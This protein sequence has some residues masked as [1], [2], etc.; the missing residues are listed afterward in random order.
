M[1]SLNN[2][3]ELV[4]VVIPCFNHGAFLKEAVDSA[5]RSKYSPIEI[6]IVDDGSSDNSGEVAG[7]IMKAHKN[8]SYY[9]QSNQGPSVARNKGIIE[10]K[11][12]YILPLDA[13]DKISNLYIEQAVDVIKSD[14]EIKIVYCNAEM[15]GSKNGPWK[16]KEYSKKRIAAHN[17]IFSCALFR[18][19]DWERI[20]GYAKEL[21][22]CDE[23]WEFWISML[24]NGGYAYK[25]ESI[26]FYYRIQC[27]SRRR[28]MT[29]ETKKHAM[30]Y[31]NSKHSSFMVS[32]LKGP[33][34]KQRSLS[35][36]I[37]II[38]NVINTMKTTAENSKVELLNQQFRLFL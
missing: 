4:S 32:Q 26:G 23:D 36:P 30:D 27:K 31:I 33:L 28:N 16:L 19:K 14:E 7:K 18:K 1:N 20:G 37:N 25:L 11:G 2:F 38:S 6:I 17:M 34:R 8:V 9:Y 15:F 5:L 12:T 13:D 29:E 35:I 22:Y 24:E 21:I 3:R 10:S